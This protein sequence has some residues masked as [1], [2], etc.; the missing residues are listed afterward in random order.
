MAWF[1]RS[2]VAVF[3]VDRAI[4][5]EGPK[6]FGPSFSLSAGGK[7][8]VLCFGDAAMASAAWAVAPSALAKGMTD[9]Q[10]ACRHL[11]QSHELAD[12]QSL[13]RRTHQ[14]IKHES[15]CPEP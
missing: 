10:P 11:V 5:D 7:R 6:P 3:R 14:R 9:E 8:R 15:D 2:T 13:R 4:E 1:S 12:A